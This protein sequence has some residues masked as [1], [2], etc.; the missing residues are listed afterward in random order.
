MDKT[1]KLMFYNTNNAFNLPFFL[2]KR[3][4]TEINSKIEFMSVLAGSAA[5]LCKLAMI[6][7]MAE[8]SHRE[9]VRARYDTLYVYN[10]LIDY[11]INFVGGGSSKWPF[12][13]IYRRIEDSSM[14]DTEASDILTTLSV[15]RNLSLLQSVTY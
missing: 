6:H 3:I 4:L 14:E 2:V 11:P 1:L 13:M 5:D 8:L 12:N 7:T 15:K 9:K 10:D